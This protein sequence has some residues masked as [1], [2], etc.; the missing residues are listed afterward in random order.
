MYSFCRNFKN[1]ESEPPVVI[2]QSTTI[3]ANGTTGLHVW[4]ACFHLI[5][6]LSRNV[7]LLSNKCVYI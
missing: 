5:S 4:P 3:I 2:E 6:Y 1:D 7:H